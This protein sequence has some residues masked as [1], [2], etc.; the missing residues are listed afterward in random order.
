[1]RFRVVLMLI[2]AA[3]IAGPAYAYGN[4]AVR[5]VAPK[6]GV[7]VH[8]NSGTLAVTVAVSP[9][10]T[11]FGGHLSLL[12]DGKT[13][14]RGTWQHFVLKGID[15]GSHT[16]RLE[17]NAADGTVLATSPQLTF[18]MWR[19]SRLFRNQHEPK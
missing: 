6:P 10:P 2:S 8:S 15:R 11:K 9:P 4:L 1:L 3:L 5:I 18:Q 19:A 14:A 17:V 7:T 12:L 16:L 13:V